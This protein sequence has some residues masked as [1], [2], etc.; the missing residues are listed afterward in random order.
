M[1]DGIFGHITTLHHA[2]H[3]EIQLGAEGR[4]EEW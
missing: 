4:G 1:N 2:L 3:I